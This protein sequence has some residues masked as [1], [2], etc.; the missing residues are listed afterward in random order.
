MPF[1]F[2]KAND[3]RASE[4]ASVFTALNKVQ[5][6]IWFDTQGNIL[7][8][9][10]NFLDAL[11]YCAED[12]V[13]QHHRMFVEPAYAASPDYTE[14]WDNLG[15]GEC[16][17]GEFTRRHKDGHPIYIE[18]SYNPVFD[19]DG[20]V[21]KIVK[22]AINVTEAKKKAA[23][24]ASQLQAIGR[25]QAV[26]EFNLDGTIL[27]ANDNFLN[28]LGY[29]LAEVQGK[30]HR[31]F[32]DKDYA[33]TQDYRRFWDDLAAGKFMADEYRRIR[34]NGASIWIQASYNPIF[35]PDGKPYKVVKYA[36]DITAAK[37]IAAE[38][39]GKLDAISR[40][41]SVIEFELDGTIINANKNFL[42][43]TG[44]DL[45]EIKGRHHAIFVDPEY[46]ASE[47]FKEFWR[48]LAK[49]EVKSSEY[50]R[51]TKT[52]QEIW[53]QANYNPI[54][55]AE[56]KPYRVV[57]Y[58]TD[59][60]P[61]KQELAVIIDSLTSLSKGDLTLRLPSD[62]LPDFAEMRSAFNTT[63][64]K[65]SELVGDIN[66]SAT[67]IQEESEAIA[68][69]AT[70]LSNRCERQA[71]TVEETSASMEEMSSTV[72]SNAN[73]AKDATSAAQNATSHAEQGGKIVQDAISAMEKIEAGSAEVRKIIEVIDA[74]AF[75]TNLLAL[76]AGVEAARAGEAGSGFAVVASEVRA[77]AQRA[78]ESARDISSLIETSERQVS[79]G[80]A[81]VK[82]TGDALNEIVGAVTRVS[83]GIDEIFTASSEQAAGVTEINQAMTEIDT[84]TQKTA[85]ISEESTA[86]AASLA[87]RATS[88]RDGVS[89]FQVTQRAPSQ[90]QVPSAHVQEDKPKAAADPAA[91]VQAASSQLALEADVDDEDWREF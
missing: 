70:D 81:L 23:D 5:A 72:K 10:D 89:F 74:I 69:S 7:E 65:L 52:G 64:E 58:A 45:S 77:L 87:Q 90:P 88:L 57:K 48:D 82:N 76:N 25:S 14:F 20:N 78:S 13:G 15:K 38:N 80:A 43:A 86:A 2:F 21:S 28:A 12:V 85:A 55:D 61:F 63:L 59:I 41:Q 79:E 46:A 31:I 18:A 32:V 44:Y 1:P 73:N 29:S 6:I 53:L 26:I 75:Q 9:N 84:P 83:S 51:F 3:P 19:D 4:L 49:G 35:D 91:V 36:T 33:A 11:G 30:N 50:K 27:D 24:S 16:V 71:A 67:S 37:A 62:G 42:D 66:F 54:F 22:F 47:S 34:K 68:D 39:S 56:G 60:T 40:A 8:A 17:S